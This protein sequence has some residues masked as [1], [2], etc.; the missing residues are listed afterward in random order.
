MIEIYH[1]RKSIEL[2]VQLYS[3]LTAVSKAGIELVNLISSTHR[4]LVLFIN[5]TTCH[6]IKPVRIDAIIDAINEG[7]LD[8]LDKPP[9]TPI[10]HHH[11]TF[12]VSK[13][14]LES[15][16]IKLEQC[17]DNLD[18]YPRSQIVYNQDRIRHL[19]ITEQQNIGEA[20]IEDNTVQLTDVQGNARL[21]VE[22]ESRALSAQKDGSFVLQNGPFMRK[23]LD[24]YFPMRV[25]IDIKLPANLSF[26]AIE[27]AEQKGFKVTRGKHSLHLDATFEGRLVTRIRFKVDP[28]RL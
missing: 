16:W 18:I 12:I 20:R 27:P 3:L 21:C 8:F 17:H 25:T 22:A 7:E 2:I 24:G 19:R 9:A 11:N 5:P 13:S 28:V 14:S 10:H 6:L 15:G 4:K 26:D 1:R 23:L